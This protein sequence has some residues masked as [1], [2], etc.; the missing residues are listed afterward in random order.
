MSVSYDFYTTAFC[1]SAISEADWPS[2]EVP[3]EAQVR[4]YKRIYTVSNPS[5]YDEE[6]D[7]DPESMAVCAL[8]ECLQAFAL[9]LSGNGAAV[10]SASI[11]S[12]SVSY[13]GAVA[14][15][16][17]LSEKGQER[18]LYRTFCKYMD[19]YRGVSPCE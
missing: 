12:V 13:S 10:S 3:A 17:D 1:G 14:G 11:G 16:V 7:P 8:A 2:F 15:A 9:L 19:V 18:E 4:R 5:D 6:T